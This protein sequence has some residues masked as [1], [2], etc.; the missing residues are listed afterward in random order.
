VLQSLP[1][2][3]LAG[4]LGG[5]TLVALGVTGFVSDDVPWPAGSQPSGAEVDELLASAV[6]LFELERQEEIFGAL[7]PPE[8]S[9]HIRANQEDI[10]AGVYTPA[11]L[12]AIGDALFE[13]AFRAFDGYADSENPPLRRVHEGIRGGL[14]TFS[15]AGCH[16]VGGPDGSG[17]LTQNA[18]LLG[19]GDDLS[20]ALARNPPHT[21][22]LGMVQALAYEMTGELTRARRDAREAA[23]ASGSSIKV[24]L[25]SKGV[26]FGFLTA[27]PDGSID[28]SEI[29][30]ISADLVVRPFG[31]KGEFALLRRF[32]E[33]AARVHFGIQSHPLAVAHELTPDPDLLGDGPDWFDPDGD[34]KVR[35]LEEGSLTA[36]AVYLALLEVPVILPPHDDG[37]RQRWASGSARFEEVGCGS[38]HRRTLS[39]TFPTWQEYPDTTASAPLSINLFSDG[40]SPR[41]TKEIEL[42]SDLKR[43]DMGDELADPYDNPAEI[44]R[45]EFL[46]RPLWGLADTAPYLH[47]G[48]ALTIPEA[49][50]AHGGEAAESRSAYE[51]LPIEQQ[52]DLHV[53]LL[54]LTRTPRLRVPR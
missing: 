48:R 41:G 49:I 35:E 23:Q 44:A 32:F 4:L 38:C 47:D 31:W 17:T 6:E 52:R 28:A 30:G 26:D 25:G 9:E 43:H 53:F 16:S 18:L 24:S 22:G 36:G 2:V 34:G 19:N 10:D 39:L 33:E 54:S 42:F 5:W 27:H 8:D 20:T 29:E 3:G 46:T 12:F 14:D 13:H 11:E 15:C 50:L 7:N 37:L 40:E 51:T 45:R 21:L 1:R